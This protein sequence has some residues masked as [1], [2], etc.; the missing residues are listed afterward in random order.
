M[1]RHALTDCFVVASELVVP[2]GGEAGLEAAFRNRLGAVDD[3]PGFLRLEVWRD[4]RAAGRY[5]LI[6]WW[7]TPESYRGYMHSQEQRTSHARIPAGALAPS[8]VSVRRFQVVT[9]AP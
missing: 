3:W 4:G 8:A 2:R 6:T 5:Q 7:D 9:D 1:T